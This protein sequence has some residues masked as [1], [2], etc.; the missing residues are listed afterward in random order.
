M[1]QRSVSHEYR[2]NLLYMSAL[3]EKKEYGKLSGY[4]KEA[5]GADMR[6]M[7]IINTNNPVIN[8][9]MNTKYY[10]AKKAGAS[11]ICKIN[12]LSGITMKETD[13]IL[14]LS[15][16][17]N[18]AIEAVEKCLDKKMIKVKIVMEN[19]KLI[20]SVWNTFNGEI[21]RD[22]DMLKTTKKENVVFHGI[23]LKN[24]VRIADKYNG[25][26]LFE[27]RGKE[28]SA[29]VII[30]MDIHYAENKSR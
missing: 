14:L 18:N 22:G 19:N 25:L 17:L 26:Y 16:L 11:F 21:K 15:N 23:G 3:L 1:Q 24:V 9:I 8:V 28:F 30:P 12:D 6:G 13:I 7:D 29:I 10:E 27:P 4:L 5:G 20:I 2:N